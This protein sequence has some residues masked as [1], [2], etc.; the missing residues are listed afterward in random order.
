M[1]KI[2]NSEITTERGTRREIE[3]VN[4]DMAIKKER[5]RDRERKREKKR[6]G[7]GL[8]GSQYALASPKIE[9]NNHHASNDAN[10][11]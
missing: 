9:R 3:E 8:S 5:E 7:R 1:E 10:A 2:E 11:K 4:C 6:I